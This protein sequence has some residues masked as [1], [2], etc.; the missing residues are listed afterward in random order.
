MPPLPMQNSQEVVEVLG[1]VQHLPIDV[2]ETYACCVSPRIGQSMV[3]Q[4][5]RIIQGRCG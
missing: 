2:K 1:N 5:G 3:I 4:F